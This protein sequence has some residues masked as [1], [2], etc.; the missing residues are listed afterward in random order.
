MSGPPIAAS[1][2]ARGPRALEIA[3]LAAILLLFLAA[4]TA[5]DIGSC[6]ESPADL[7]PVKFFVAKENIDC[8]MC[9]ECGMVT[10]ACERACDAKPNQTGFP[11][12]C[13]PLIHDGE[14]CL[15]ALEASGCDEYRGFMA[16]EGATVPTECNF[17]PSQPTS[18]PT[19][20]GA[21]GATSEAPEGE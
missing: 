3:R 13:F 5:G 14:V 6:G 15:N 11:L 21:D 10:L 2:R 8:G 18:I 19:D 12:G 7:N 9:S 16:D 4:P 1:S 20:A 17:C